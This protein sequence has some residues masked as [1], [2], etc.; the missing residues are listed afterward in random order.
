MDKGSIDDLLEVARQ[1]LDG[2]SERGAGDAEA[3]SE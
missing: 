3:R 2:D 1:I